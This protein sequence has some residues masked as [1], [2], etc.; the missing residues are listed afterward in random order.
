[1][2]TQTIGM[3]SLPST[4]TALT[5]LFMILFFTMTQIAHGA[6]APSRP[7]TTSE[8]AAQK[9]AKANEYFKQGK[10]FRK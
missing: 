8:S 6:G 7:G 9:R 4:M 3:H 2:R 10:R 1:M 5:L